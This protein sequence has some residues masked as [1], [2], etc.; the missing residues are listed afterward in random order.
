[1][2][3]EIDLDLHGHEWLA[4]KLSANQVRY[5][6]HDNVFLWIEDMA[7]AQTFADRFVNLNWPT[8]LEKYAKRVNP[9]WD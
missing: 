2:S 7:N 5:T 6:K 4:R 8:I 1:M 3:I 9:S